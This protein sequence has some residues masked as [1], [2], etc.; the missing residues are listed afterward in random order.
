MTRKNQEASIRRIERQMEQLV[1][2]LAEM[3]EK[4]ANTFPRATED[5]LKDNEK[6]ARWEKWKEIIEGSERATEKET[7]IK[8]KHHREV[9][10]EEIE[11]KKP[12]VRGETQRQQNS[13]LP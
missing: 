13:Q 1:E 11:E 7:I 4:R 8:E 6:V 3:G 10:Q 2:Y 9:P 12:T 5:N